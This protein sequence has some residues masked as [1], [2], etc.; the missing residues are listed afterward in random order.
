MECTRW[1]IH[2]RFNFLMVTSDKIVIIDH[3]SFFRQ[4]VN[5]IHLQNIVRS[6]S[7]SQFFGLF[8]CGIVELR[9]EEKVEGTARVFR[10]G[11]IPSQAT[12]ASAIENAIALKQRIAAGSET[13]KQEEKKVEAI[14]EILHEQAPNAAIETKDPQKPA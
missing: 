10:M 6:Q 4:N 12:V 1:Y 5:S 11:Y 14:K 2:W 9:L 3:H 13:P 7:E 8:R